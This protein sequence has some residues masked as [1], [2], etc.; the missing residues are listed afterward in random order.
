MTKK[1]IAIVSILVMIIVSGCK[2]TVLVDTMTDPLGI[3]T[4]PTETVQIETEM[5]VT[6]VPDPT[7]PDLS[8]LVTE[9]DMSSYNLFFEQ[10][11]V[12]ER[13]FYYLNHNHWKV[14]GSDTEY[15]I[16][17][18][19]EGL[20]V[21]AFG[22]REVYTIPGSDAL[23][24]ILHIFTNGA[25]V[26]CISSEMEMFYLDP[27][28]GRITEHMG[29]VLD[30]LYLFNDE[31]LY[32]AVLEGDTIRCCRL[33]VPTLTLDV[34]CDDIPGNV[35]GNWFMMLPPETN[36]SPIGWRMMNPEFYPVVKSVLE[37]PDSA[38]RELYPWMWE[39]DPIGTGGFNDNGYNVMVNLI[40]RIQHDFGIP[41]YIQASFDVISGEYSERAYYLGE[42]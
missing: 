35:P 27:V 20:C 30:Q 5:T 42:G 12:L 22:G 37:D 38:Y 11:Q 17:R 33:H 7:E 18:T 10:E 8:W 40:K 31:V 41:P 28:T 1:R 32:F 19:G 26:C 3:D 14:P 4:V 15:T 39:E 23:G 2:K 34:I 21:A 13:S 9:P 36:L 29:Q 6:T 25:E 16:R 24:Q